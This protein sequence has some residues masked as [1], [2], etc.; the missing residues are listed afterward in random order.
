MSDI[1]PKQGKVWRLSRWGL[2]ALHQSRVLVI[3]HPDNPQVMQQRARAIRNA[4]KVFARRNGMG[5][6]VRVRI[7]G[8]RYCTIIEREEGWTGM[9]SR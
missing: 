9:R 1:A 5:L 2:G 7:E 8:G 6:R 3:A 4:A